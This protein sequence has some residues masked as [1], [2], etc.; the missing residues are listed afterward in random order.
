MGRL[1]YLPVLCIFTLLAQTAD[2]GSGAASEAIRRDF[3]RAYFR[4][5]F[6][7]ITAFPPSTHVKA[8]GGTALRQDFQ[9]A[10]KTGLV[11]ALIRN[12]NTNTSGADSTENTFQVFPDVLAYYDTLKSSDTGFPATDTIGCIAVSGNTCTY[13]FFDKNYALFAY[14]SDVGGRGKAFS[15]KDPFFSRW[16]SLGGMGTFGPASAAEETT[17]SAAGT[18]AT[19]QRFQYGAIYSITSGLNTGKL[20]SVRRPIYDVFSANT[21]L[22][23]P[24]SDELTVSETRRRQ[25]F[26]GGAIEYT[27]GGEAVLLLPVSTV[28]VTVAPTV[29]QLNLGDTIQLTAVTYAADGAVLQNRTV[30]WVSTNPRVLSVAVGGVTVTARAVGGGTAT[31]TAVSEGKSSR[32]TTFFVTAPC[33]QVGEGAPT[34]AIQQSFIDA[35]SRNRLTVKIPAPGPVRRLGNGYV[36]E[37]LSADGATR[38]L[39][40]K[41]DALANTFIVAAANLARYLELGGPTGSLGFPLADP[42]SAGRQLFEAGALAGTPP[43][44]VSPP[45]LARW[46]SAGYESGAAGLPT[47]PAQS[48]LSFTANLA[49]SQAFT[50]STYHAYLTGSLS[51]RAF[52][53][54]GPINTKYVAAG[55][56]SGKLGLPTSDEFPSAGH[57]RQEF[58]GGAI[59]YTPGAAE[60]QVEERARRAQIAATPSTVAPGTRLRI[61]AGG[62]DAGATL[63]ITVGS[64]PDIVVKAVTGAYAWELYVPSNAT[65][66]LVNLRAA[67]INGSALAVGSYVIQSSSET[68][69]RVVK[70]SGDLQTGAPGARLPQPIRVLVRDDAGNALPGLPV[71]FNPSPGAQ[72][73]AASAVTDERGAALA[74][75]RLPTAELP[76]LATAEA[77]GSVV[78]FSARTQASSLT[79]F[80]KFTA[81]QPSDAL[82]TSAAAIVRYLQQTALAGSAN[83]SAD[84]AVL[85]QFLRGFCLFDPSGAKICDGYFGQTPNLW[86]LS[87]FAAS[88]LEPAPVELSANAIRDQL[89]QGVPVLLALA[90]YYGETP[91]ATHFVVAIGVNS[92]GGVLIQDPLPSLQR[93]SLDDYLSGTLFNNVRLVPRLAGA[94]RFATQSGSSLGLLVVGG[95]DSAPITSVSGPC[96]FAIGWPSSPLIPSA[97]STNPTSF[98]WFRFCD[99]RET[100]YQLDLSGL[101]GAAPALYSLGAVSARTDLASLAPGV[102]QLTRPDTVWTASPQRLSFD[103]AAVLNSASLAPALAPGLLATVLGR[104]LASASQQPAVALNDRPLS[105]LYSSPFQVNFVIPPDAAPGPYRLRITS[106]FGDQ[107]QAITLD[108]VAPALYSMPGN[109]AAA[110]NPDGTLNAPASAVSRGQVLVVYGTGLGAVTPSG[111]LQAV[112]T[113]VRAFIEDNPLDVLFAGAA[114]SLPGVY[115]LNLRIPASL[116][117]GIDLRLAIEQAGSRSQPVLVTVQ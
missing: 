32:G 81:P 57:R 94:L 88:A 12:N 83:G 25:T 75:L 84:P 67:D 90:Y 50:N 41:P 40:A 93:G 80:P 70:L 48:V 64:Q 35:V 65:P 110:V 26:E 116:P 44:V 73:E 33:C 9:D 29:Q 78:T 46:A 55:G 13:Q 72:I 17:T 76:A 107:D 27:L 11:Y 86:R 87:A 108:A 24:T 20:F 3:L 58:E 4:N 101:T 100:S 43:Q 47:G 49:A 79:N 117:P 54:A 18:T 92:G 66:G 5:G 102:V 34:P 59:D 63:R 62:F 42:S 15:T 39:A 45:I 7:N 68:L 36:Q 82:V 61:A 69:A 22:G 30:A 6:S 2:V 23:L 14:A 8:F 56:P 98:Q 89:A 103:A 74:Y 77:G 106:P 21:F 99:G 1:R 85:S 97:V 104:G 28:S 109:R 111:S 52:L 10:A 113:P 115:Q 105:V 16:R 112:T 31:I 95:G 60:A 51:N 114:P 71:R 19:L 53:T 37:L 38:Y 96:G 91:V